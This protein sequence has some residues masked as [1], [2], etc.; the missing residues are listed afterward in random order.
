MVSKNCIL[1]AFVVCALVSLASVALA[2]VSVTSPGFAG[3]NQILTFGVGHGCEGADTVQLRVDIPEEIMS[4]RA[5]PSPWGEAEVTRNDEDLVTAVTWTKADARPF[6][7]QYYQFSIRVGVPDA[8]FTTLYF[9]ATQICRN[10]DGEE[11]TAEWSALPEEVEAAGEDA[12]LL[13]APALLIL[14]PRV[15][16]WNKYTVADDI[17]DLS[18][19][20][21]AQIV[22]SGDAAYSANL[23]TAAL[24]E[25]EEDV[26]VLT[27]IEADAEIW[28]KY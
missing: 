20:D 28:V 3:T 1:A 17:T 15:P 13:E 16:G 14:P 8:P 7:D 5:L 26:E 25:D 18:I 12:E 4:V 10:A 19:F 22:W 24:I 6:D 11:I 21:D 27:E 9:E 23:E 2:H